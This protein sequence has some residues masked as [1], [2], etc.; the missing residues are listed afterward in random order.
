M[1]TEARLGIRPVNNWA[2][3]LIWI[4][5]FCSVAVACGNSGGDSGTSSGLTY[6][7]DTSQAVI[8]SKNVQAI[9]ANP[10][11][12]GSGGV[13]I[14]G[15]PGINNT[16]QATRRPIFM[17][18]AMVVKSAIAEMDQ[19]SVA[20]QDPSSA[21][22]ADT[23]PGSC[24]GEYSY[25]IQY[26]RYT[27]VLSG[28]LAFNDFCD[29]G[30][31]LN[32]STSFSGA[33]N[34]GTKQVDSCTLSFNSITGTSNAKS[35]TIGGHVYLAE[36]GAT[37]MLTMDMMIRDEGTGHVCKIEN[38]QMD[39]T[40]RGTCAQITVNGRYYDPEYG[41]IDLET[42]TTFMVAYADNHL[43]SGQ[44]V[45]IGG[46]GTAGGPT[47]ARL[48]ALSATECQVEADTD[49]DGTYDYNTGAVPWTDL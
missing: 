16:N 1:I 6:S 21:I 7:G 37:T 45:L 28:D 47:K 39:I 34:T 25:N 10:M 19:Q 30:M 40:D 15:I 12:T 41:Y 42:T 20:D 46:N 4:I 17:G 2:S 29:D 3:L 9:A 11:D 49:G 26:D 5:V 32:G 18:V 8:T 44:L 43:C 24:G 33:I 14:S 35:M 48:T 36:S 27:N 13:V 31:T 38:Y 23:Y 22:Q